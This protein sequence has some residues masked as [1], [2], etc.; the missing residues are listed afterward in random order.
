MTA[1]L[2]ESFVRVLVV[3]DSSENRLS[4]VRLL[5]RAGFEV[6]EADNGSSGVEACE[7]WR[8]DVVLMD[9]QMPVLD[10]VGATRRIKATV[11]GRGI[12]V[13]F[14]SGETS[15]ASVADAMAAGAIAFIGKP[16]VD[17]EILDA[18]ASV[19]ER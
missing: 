16:F 6:R 12:P 11:W 17:S 7:Q 9:G 10:G 3:D 19:L 1:P 2:G 15:Q 18:L 4:L 14:V 13:I 5:E 8:P